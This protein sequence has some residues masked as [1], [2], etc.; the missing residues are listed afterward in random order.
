MAGVLTCTT[1]RKGG[2][3]M[4]MVIST[5]SYFFFTVKDPNIASLKIK[6]IKLGNNHQN[7]TNVGNLSATIQKLISM[8]LT[9]VTS[10]D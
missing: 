6:P 7:T 1:F 4:E 9:T 10:L 8:A 2:Q 5:R 3:A